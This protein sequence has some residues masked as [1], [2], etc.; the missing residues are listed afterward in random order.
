[1]FNRSGTIGPKRGSE[2]PAALTN[3]AASRVKHFHPTEPSRCDLPSRILKCELLE[4]AR[5]TQAI[6]GREPA[7]IPLVLFDDQKW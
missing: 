6:R 1:M 3:Y 4:P 5:P 2:K 7:K